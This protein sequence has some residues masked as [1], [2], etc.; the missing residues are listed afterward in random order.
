MLFVARL[1]W[2]NGM[3]LSLRVK[4]VYFTSAKNVS[5]SC[6]ERCVWDACVDFVMGM[7]IY[8]EPHFLLN[9]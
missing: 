4:A 9:N 7:K 5:I 1:L 6:D 2:L 8:Q 3:R